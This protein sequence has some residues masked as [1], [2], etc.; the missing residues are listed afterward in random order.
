MRF[1]KGSALILSARHEEIDNTDDDVTNASTSL[2]AQWNQRYSD[3]LR[4]SLLTIWR[5]EDNSDGVDGQGLEHRFDLN[6]DYRQTSLYATLRYATTDS[7]V[8]DTSFLTFLV[9]VR[10]EF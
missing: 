5:N 3:R 7:D 6:W 1:G 4:T 10:R 2:T 9:G 8:N